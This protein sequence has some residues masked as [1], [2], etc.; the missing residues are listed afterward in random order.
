MTTR[1]LLA[2]SNLLA[3]C[4]TAGLLKKSTAHPVKLEVNAWPAS[5]LA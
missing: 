5:A 2:D 4:L 3:R 1:Q